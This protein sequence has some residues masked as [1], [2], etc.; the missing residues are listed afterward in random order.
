M[1][2][3]K[4][5]TNSSSNTTLLPLSRSNFILG[6]TAIDDD[7]RTKNSKKSYSN[8]FWT[9]PS[10][11]PNAAMVVVVLGLL[12]FVCGVLLYCPRYYTIIHEWHVN[13]A[14]DDDVAATAVQSPHIPMTPDLLIRI[15]SNTTTPEDNLFFISSKPPPLFVLGA[16]KCGTTAIY[17][18]LM[19]H[20]QLYRANSFSDDIISAATKELN[21]FADDRN[22]IKGIINYE[23]RLDVDWGQ[24]SKTTPGYVV[25]ATPL[26]LM[27]AQTAPRI[28][29]AYGDKP[30]KFIILLRDPIEA[31]YSMYQMLEYVVTHANVINTK[32]GT[33]FA[34]VFLTRFPTFASLVTTLMDDYEACADKHVGNGEL[35]TWQQCFQQTEPTNKVLLQY[36]FDP[37]I[38]HWMGIFPPHYFCIINNNFLRDNKTEALN[39]VTSFVGLHAFNW[40]QASVDQYVGIQ[41]S[42]VPL[43][44][45]LYNTLDQ[46]YMRHGRRHYDQASINGYTGCV[47]DQGEGV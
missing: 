31:V 35:H 6:T 5:G 13:A 1:T 37:Q 38:D 14:D 33:W 22:Y 9:L 17:H 15:L 39:I 42:D 40:T 32:E 3:T 20:P 26:Y 23:A 21:Y 46:F 7:L 8:V 16:A 43:S 36:I 18:Y 30:L 12:M 47:P 2:M 34:Q 28:R 10:E 44:N 11:T 29:L 24:N 45:D 4:H 19:H 25:D 41:Q 27:Y